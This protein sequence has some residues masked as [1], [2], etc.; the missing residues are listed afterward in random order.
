M[1]PAA[2]AGGVRG[3]LGLAE[4]RSGAPYGRSTSGTSPWK[5]SRIASAI[6][7]TTAVPFRVCTGSARARRDS[8]SPSRRAWK[9]VV[10]EI[11]AVSR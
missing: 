11:E 1:L 10:F 6:R 3:G 7:S 4:T 2:R 9:S 5:F 8:G